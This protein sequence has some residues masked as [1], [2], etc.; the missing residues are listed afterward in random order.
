MTTPS[1]ISLAIVLIGAGVFLMG[2]AR[3]I[4]ALRP[5]EWEIE[6]RRTLWRK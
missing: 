2:L 6:R 1:P 5:R 3:F 4:D